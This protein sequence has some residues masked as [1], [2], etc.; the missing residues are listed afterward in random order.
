ME[1][2]CLHISADY[3]CYLNDRWFRQHEY[4]EKLNM[5]AILNAAATQEE[6]VQE[7]FVS[8]GKVR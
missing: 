3:F 1:P 8:F 5:Q 2:Q 6:Y 4:I 7:L